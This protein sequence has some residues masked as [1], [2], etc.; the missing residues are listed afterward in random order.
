[1]IFDIVSLTQG[2][3]AKNDVAV[4]TQLVDGLQPIEGDRVQLQQVILNLVM[5]AIEA[6]SGTDEPPR[7]LLLTSE[8]AEPG[9]VRVSVRDTGPGLGSPAP[10]RLFHAFHTT[11]ANGLGLG[12]SICRSIIEAH[13]GKL[14]AAANSPRGAVF[15]F[16][17]PTIAA[18][19]QTVD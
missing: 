6:M 8:E 13:G 1:V 12:L 11:K 18:G 3:A 9:R 15:Q 14:S 10:D 7:E 4:R 16:V 5:N 19:R 17:V 2:E